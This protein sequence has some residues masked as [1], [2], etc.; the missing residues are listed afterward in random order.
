MPFEKQS[1]NAPL[2]TES[3]IF[4]EPDVIDISEEP[5]VFEENQANS[6]NE[7]ENPK[8]EESSETKTADEN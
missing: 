1:E 6:Q 2:E 8:N 3:K 5:E 4:A 7:N